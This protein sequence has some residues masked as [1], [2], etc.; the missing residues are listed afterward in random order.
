MHDQ[1]RID[2]FHVLGYE[3]ELLHALRIDLLL[4]AE[5]GRLERENYFASPFYRFN[6]LFKPPGRR[7]RAKLVGSVN[8]HGSSGQYCRTENP[9]DITT[10]AYVVTSTTD[11]SNVI[12]R[13]HIAAG[14]EAQ[15][16]IA[17]AGSILTE[18]GKTDGRVAVAGDVACGGSETQGDVLLA[19]CVI[20]ERLAADCRV[21]K[22]GGVAHE[23]FEPES[24]VGTDRLFFAS[25]L[26]PTACTLA[27][28]GDRAERV[29]TYRSVRTTSGVAG[30]T[31]LHRLPC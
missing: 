20:E 8:Q 22:P 23:C 14:L 15:G 12:G 27:L 18:S 24:V 6:L 11:A 21:E 9:S 29:K 1:T 25:A 10:V 26:N 30:E 2:L 3:A 19:C 31:N 28:V 16:D 7:G 4:V 17:G 13:S 5:G